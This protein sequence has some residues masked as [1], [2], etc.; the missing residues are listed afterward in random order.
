VLLRDVEKHL[1]K[2]EITD[3]VLQILESIIMKV[4]INKQDLKCI[5]DLVIS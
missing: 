1:R 5:L 3:D 4:V 2:A